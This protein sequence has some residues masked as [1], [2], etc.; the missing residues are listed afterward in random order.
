MHRNKYKSCTNNNKKNINAVYLVSTW[1]LSVKRHA[2]T[3]VELSVLPLYSYRA[4]QLSA[5]S[6]L[7]KVST[8]Y[9]PRVTRRQED[10]DS[11]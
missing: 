10:D 2:N 11:D 9:Q 1:S 5:T 4:K 8:I 7:K 3:L 6:L